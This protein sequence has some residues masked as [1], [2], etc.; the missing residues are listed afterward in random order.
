MALSPE[1]L[2]L[3]KHDELVAS[4]GKPG[5]IV[6]KTRLLLPV[7][8]IWQPAD[9]LPGPREEEKPP[10]TKAEMDAADEKYTLQVLQLRRMAREL[11]DS[12]LVVLVGNAVTEEAIPAYMA[13]LNRVNAIADKTGADDLPWPKW[14][15]GWTAEESRHD[16]VLDFWMRESGRLNMHSVD[17]TKHSLILRG[18]D[19]KV[20]DD[21]YR[22]FT[23]TAFQELATKISHDREGKMALQA[24]GSESILAKICGFIAGDESRHYTFY[25]DIMGHIFDQDPDGAMIAFRDM[26]E[27]EVAM[28]GAFMN[29]GSIDDGSDATEKNGKQASLFDRYA[30]VAQSEGIYTATDYVTITRDLIGKW[31][32]LDRVVSSDEAKKAQDKLGFWTQDRAMAI[33]NRVQ[34]RAIRKIHNPKFP[35][36]HNREISL[37]R[38]A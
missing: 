25:S 9:L 19:P 11:P 15:R 21:P 3:G 10:E 26:M 2:E 31:K 1:A 28:P 14:V 5:G 12:I 38:A 7:A 18:F 32:V 30:A 22:A 8:R 27:E 20:G 4:F 36:I 16:H 24:E 6:D 17:R 37:K 34:E 23:Y 35:W 13:W 33:S 29:D